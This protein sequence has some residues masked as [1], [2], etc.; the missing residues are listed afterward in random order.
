MAS[1]S[2]SARSR[3]VA[4]LLQPKRVLHVLVRGRFLVGLHRRVDVRTEHQRLPPVRHRQTRIEARGFAE[5]AAR[6][7]VVERVGE[8][9]SLVD[10]TLR[11]RAACRHRER[12]R[13]QILKPRGEGAGRRRLL[14][15]RRVVHVTTGVGGLREQR[16]S[17]ASA[18]GYQRHEPTVT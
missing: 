13:S 9:Q 15:R 2:I 8:I 10:E 7:G 12:M 14:L 4:V 3:G 16:A 5:R 11:G 17:Q 6:L 1:A 18:R